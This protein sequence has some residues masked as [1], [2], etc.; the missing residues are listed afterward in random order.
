MRKTM[1]FILVIG[2]SSLYGTTGIINKDVKIR[3][4]PSMK[5]KTVATRKKGRELE[6]LQKVDGGKDGYFYQTP[7]GFVYETFITLN[8]EPDV[9]EVPLQKDVLKVENNITTE[10]INNT[11]QKIEIMKID[12]VTEEVIPVTPVLIVPLRTNNES[13]TKEIVVE[14]KETP[15]QHVVVVKIAED[16]AQATSSQEIITDSLPPKV[17]VENQIVAEDKQEKSAEVG[18]EDSKVASKGE[19]NIAN[20]QTEVKSSPI[21]PPIIKEQ[22]KNFVGLSLNLNSLSVKQHNEIGTITLPRKLDDQGTS[23]TFQLGTKLKKDYIL[24]GNF[25]TINLAD[26]K[27]NSYFLSVDYQLPYFLNPYLGIS[28]GMSDLEWQRDPLVKS[29]TKDT[30][31]SSFL[32]GIQ[33]GVSYPIED[34][35][36]IVSQFSYQKL[37]FKTNLT[38]TPAKGNITHD[39]KKSLGIGLRHSF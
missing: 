22:P 18:Y 10:E 23:F 25:E 1:P 26:V 24:S 11:T 16:M 2:V 19:E 14:Q 3:E 5:A 6:I 15:S 13:N 4:F 21:Q 29:T 9:I 39:D 27:I 8:E 30:Q 35:W 7:K 32:Y 17:Y 34:T 37:D 20:E 36:S 38:S 33:G 28:L 12:S 31:L